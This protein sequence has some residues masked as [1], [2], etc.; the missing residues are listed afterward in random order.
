MANQEEWIIVPIHTTLI[1]LIII[2]VSRTRF[3]HLCISSQPLRHQGNP[4]PY[5]FVP[6]F[7]FFFCPTQVC[8]EFLAF[9]EVW[10]LLP[11]FSMCSAGVVPHVDIFLMY[12]WEG[13]LSSRL[14]PLPSWRSSL[15]ILLFC[16]LFLFFAVLYF[17]FGVE[18]LTH[19]FHFY[20]YW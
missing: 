9:W 15:V 13:S 1:F 20:W 12:L 14:T 11:V 4:H 8:G 2:P 16:F 17:T 5:S 7:S 18:G 10:G 19:L 3:A 6:A